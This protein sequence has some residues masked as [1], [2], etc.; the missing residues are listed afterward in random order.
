MANSV[1]PPSGAG[2]ETHL[3]AQP[4][5]PPAAPTPPAKLRPARTWYWVALVVFLA[6]AGWLGAGLYMLVERVDSFQRVTLPGEGEVSLDHSGGYVIYYE[7]P[8]AAEGNVPDFTVNVTPL[9]ESAV[10]QDLEAYGGGLTYSFGSREG[11]AVLTLQVASP[12]RFLIEAPDAPAMPGGSSLA[13][14]SSVAGSIVGIALPSVVL[15]VVGV[16]GAI[17]VAIVRRRR[18]RGFRATGHY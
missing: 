4:T 8:G 10:V 7:G 16:G 17:G 3:P 9:S 13:I 2:Q 15:M 6:G 12:G 18:R 11:R 5:K 1:T 14:G